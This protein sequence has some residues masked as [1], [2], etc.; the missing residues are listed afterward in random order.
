MRD[1]IVNDDKVFNDADF[2][3]YLLKKR[4]VQSGTEKYYVSWVGSF[5]H[6]RSQWSGYSW[7]D[8]LSFF[9]EKLNA[10]VNI[11]TWHVRQADHAVRLY[12]TTFLQEKGIVNSVVPSIV[13]NKGDSYS[14]KNILE[15]FHKSLRL[16]NYAIRTEKIYLHWARSFL[17]Y[18]KNQNNID[19]NSF[20]LQHVKELVKDYLAYLAC[21][22]KVSAST[23]NQAFN[24]LLMLFR[25][26]WNYELSDMRQHVRAKVSRKL[27]TVLSQDEVFKLLN[28]FNGTMKL[29]IELIYGGGLRIQECMRLRIK[30]IDF[31]QD[32]TIIHSGKG[33]KDRTT[34]LPH[35]LRDS[36]KD[37]IKNVIDLHQKDI[38]E[39]YGE[40]WMPEALVRKYPKAATETAWQWLFP[41]NRRSIDPNSGQIRRHHLYNRTVQKALKKAAT[42]SEIHKHVSVHTLRHSFAT[43]LLL[44]GVDIR[45][46]QEFLGHSKLE[47][48]MIYTHVIKNMRDPAT[49]PLDILNKS[50]MKN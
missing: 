43:H 33:D 45:Q 17:V 10:R 23:Q 42:K 9:L 6:M 19:Q 12:F 26:V 1:N 29:I 46:I 32:L 2:G 14:E 31:D 35:S 47:T 15:E 20:S 3:E 38:A 44:A 11:E 49:S 5:Y 30:D 41:S 25:L 48:T 37:H 4:I 34:L 18:S 21:H 27:P 50:S 16:K 39:G 36:L 24:A 28:Q 13:A 22:K 7:L 8:Q 40:V